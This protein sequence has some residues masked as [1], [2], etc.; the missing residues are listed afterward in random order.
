MER[1]LPKAGEIWQHFKQKEYKIVACPVTHT[2]TR[3]QLVCYQALYGDYGYFVR[4]MDMFMGPT[5]KVKYPE[6]R[7]EFRFMK[8]RDA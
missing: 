4:P 7:Q 2:E 8:K 1:E 3:E 5:D 6:A